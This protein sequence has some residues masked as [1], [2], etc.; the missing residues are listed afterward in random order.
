MGNAKGGSDGQREVGAMM[1]HI[2]IHKCVYW[3]CSSDTL[4]HRQ[5][6][7]G[8]VRFADVVPI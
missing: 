7:D 4:F 5:P 8:G 1:N 2:I 3:V 6:R